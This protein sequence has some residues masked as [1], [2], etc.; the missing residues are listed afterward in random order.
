MGTK[1]ILNFIQNAKGKKTGNSVMNSASG[2]WQRAGG[3]IYVA[4][5]YVRVQTVVPMV[6]VWGKKEKKR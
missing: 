6:K 3:G 5:S 2:D 4:F 1:V